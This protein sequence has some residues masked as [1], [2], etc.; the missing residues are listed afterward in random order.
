LWVGVAAA[1]NAAPIHLVYDV[2]AGCPSQA[3]F[4]DM[5]RRDGGQVDVVADDTAAPSFA[6]HVEGRDTVVGRLV[7]T[8]DDG[9]EATREIA[10]AHCEDVIR[11]LAVLVALAAQP[12]PPSGDA[13][14]APEPAAAV[15]S[16]GAAISSDDVALEPTAGDTDTST[17][18]REPRWRL[19]VASQGTLDT[20]VGTTVDPGFAAY[21][22]VV[23]DAPGLFA[24]TLRAGVELPLDQS[25]GFNAVT[26]HRVVGRLDA[27]PWRLVASQPWSE[28]ALTLT[29]CARLDAG[30]LHAQG[31]IAV[32]RPWI[33]PAA[34][35]RAR[36]TSPRFFVEL[37]A[38]AAFP[39][40]RERFG[41]E[42]SD[43]VPA[44]GAAG[45]L[46]FGVFFL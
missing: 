11:S 38:G 21:V 8:G 29:A 1:Q 17:P 46:G 12:H 28:D 36:W 19:D 16:L 42:A 44:A 45:G 22:E 32:D 41:S 20:G 31:G 37:E 2:T 9:A 35:L 4:L 30:Q 24:P 7:V 13:P 26:Y 34:L 3:A 5:V 40:V 25:D 39:I 6:V 14:A 43:E 27:C 33:T 23:H 15:P 10:V 18:A